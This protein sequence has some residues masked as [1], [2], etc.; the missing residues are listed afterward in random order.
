MKRDHRSDDC[1]EVQLDENDSPKFRV[2]VRFSEDWRRI[3]FSHGEEFDEWADDVERG[4]EKRVNEFL[5]K[6]PLV[7]NWD[8]AFDSKKRTGE[9]EVDWYGCR[10]TA[11]VGRKRDDLEDE[12]IREVRSFWVHYVR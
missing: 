10:F 12:V 6:H 11:D 5:E 4:M 1:H 8:I 3:V 7:D 2:S 9:V